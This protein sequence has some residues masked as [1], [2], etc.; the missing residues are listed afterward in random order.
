MGSQSARTVCC[1]ST[2]TDKRLPSGRSDHSTNLLDRLATA[3]VRASMSAALAAFEQPMKHAPVCGKLSNTPSSSSALAL[4]LWRRLTKVAGRARSS[5]IIMASSVVRLEN[6]RTKAAIL[7]WSQALARCMSARLRHCTSSTT[8][9]E[10][11]PKKSSGASRRDRTS[12][13]A[14][15]A[16]AAL[17]GWACSASKASARSHSARRMRPMANEVDAAALR[18]GYEGVSTHTG[19][20]LSILQAVSSL[21]SWC[22]AIEMARWPS[23]LSS[24]M[25]MASVN[26]RSCDAVA[27]SSR[28]SEMA[29]AAMMAHEKPPK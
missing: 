15:A 28:A 9:C 7:E 18:T 8:K 5:S 4:S 21:S 14:A 23:M 6:S 22:S 1:E 20:E 16:S 2:A 11:S 25:R 29:R 10:C 3:R 13:A 19:V 17:F 27:I 12:E 24:N 26:K